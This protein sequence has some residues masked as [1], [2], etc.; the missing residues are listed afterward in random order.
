MKAIVLTFDEQTGIAEMVYKRYMEIWPDCPLKFVIPFNSET[1]PCIEYFSSRSN[2]T[3]LQSKPDVV[4]TVSSLLDGI[5][6]QEW[7][8]WCIDDRYPLSIR[9]AVPLARITNFL[10]TQGNSELRAVKLFRGK[11]KL[12]SKTYRIDDLLFY[13]QSCKTMWGF[14]HHHFLRAGILREFFLG[15]KMMT[16]KGIKSICDIHMYHEEKYHRRNK[17]NTQ[18]VLLPHENIVESFLEPTRKGRLTTS[19]LQL[20]G[21]YECHQIPAYEPIS[22][23]IHQ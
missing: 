19:A 20:L 4:S 6:D 10:E 13:Y 8:F 18:G 12:S 5:P 11:E 22:C 17:F 21:Y 23:I 2:V 3:L 9:N 14:Y 1:N 16:E 15:K 7:V